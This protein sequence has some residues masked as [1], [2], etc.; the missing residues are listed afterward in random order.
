MNYMDIN[1]RVDNPTRNEPRY[2][3]IHLNTLSES[4]WNMGT[5]IL[6][7]IFTSGLVSSLW[8]SNCR[9]FG[10]PVALARTLASS[11]VFS[12]RHKRVVWCSNNPTCIRELTASS[13][14]A[15]TSSVNGY[16]RFLVFFASVSW[17]CKFLLECICDWVLG[18]VAFWF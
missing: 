18:F 16:L 13:D 8:N 10:T 1:I 17:F 15:N 6:T 11:N 7:S 14:S 4:K 12:R 3:N 9:S 5:A 2:T